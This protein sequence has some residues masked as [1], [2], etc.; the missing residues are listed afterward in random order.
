VK[1][2]RVPEA[3]VQEGYCRSHALRRL[4]ALQKRNPEF[5]VLIPRASERDKWLVNPIGLKRAI[6]AER[7]TQGAEVLDRM[8]AI[9]SATAKMQ[10]KTHRLEMRISNMENNGLRRVGQR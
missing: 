4:K 6:E 9:E 5:E 2:I 1:P 3:A 7:G 10:R 8:A